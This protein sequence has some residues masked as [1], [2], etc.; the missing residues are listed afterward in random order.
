[1]PAA[2]LVLLTGCATP[3]STLWPQ[4]PGAARIAELWW[5][6]FSIGSAIFLAVTG[7]VLYALLRARNGQ[8]AGARPPVGADWL[9]GLGGVALPAVV[10]LVLFT[11]SLR[12]MMLLSP[13]E[14]ASGVTIQVIGHQWW[15]DV[16]Y[17]EE[18]V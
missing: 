9:I 6:S 13:P 12:A 15:W 2:S 17:P 7:L 4:G 10:G 5:L 14:S 16:R 11:T 18:Q 1:M 8:T 3:Q